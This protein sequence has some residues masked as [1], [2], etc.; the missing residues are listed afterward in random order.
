MAMGYG[1][2]KIGEN[3]RKT[4]VNRSRPIAQ[5]NS[6]AIAPT[7]VGLRVIGRGEFRRNRSANNFRGI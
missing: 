2:S 3:S 5:P 4:L 1:H 7:A 6:M